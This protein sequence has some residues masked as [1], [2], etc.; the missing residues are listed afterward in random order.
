MRK[1]LG[2]TSLRTLTLK[3]RTMQTRL[4]HYSL[5][6]VFSS[7]SLVVSRHD[8]LTAFLLRSIGTQSG[9]ICRK[10]RSFSGVTTVRD[11]PVGL[12]VDVEALVLVTDVK[13][14]SATGV[15][16]TR[17]TAVIGLPVVAKVILTYYKNYYN[18]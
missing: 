9:F 13:R 7:F 8:I 6:Y 5:C 2:A 12:T 11:S 4:V 3:R 10:S 17:L 18:K 15:G 14:S 16:V 1:N